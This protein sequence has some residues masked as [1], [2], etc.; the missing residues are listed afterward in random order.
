MNPLLTKLDR[1]GFPMIWIPVIK[2]HMHWLPV[3]KI[4]FEHFLC[5]TSDSRFDATWYD[6]ILG[7]NPR[8]S[9]GSIRESNYWQT[10]ITGVRP[11]EALKF[12]DWC[13]D[14]Y[15]L[16]TL[17]E[18]F[19]SYETL[20]TL[21]AEPKAVAE[22]CAD[23]GLSERATALLARIEAAGQAAF[24][25]MEILPAP[26]L[27]DQMFMRGG[28]MEWVEWQGQQTRWGGM[29]RPNRRF[30]GVLFNPDMG[31]PHEVNNPEGEPLPYYGF[32]LIQRDP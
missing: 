31:R 12:A 18:W 13:G 32:R 9:P 19:A 4:Q 29:G 1:A 5:S 22:I 20:K 15:G 11:S 23:H 25:H 7:Y 6:R 17:K 21:P 3:T 27:A 14:G 26:T 8:I 24:R 2:A 30:G 10:F 28:V 16:P